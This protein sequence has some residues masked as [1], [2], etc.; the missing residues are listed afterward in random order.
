MSD[1]NP[2]IQPH[3]T[4]M[5]ELARRGSE[6]YHYPKLPVLN[7]D[8]HR[9]IGQM[10]LTDGVPIIRENVITSEETSGVGWPE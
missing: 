7:A 5:I 6:M 3:A 8:Q 9:K 2:R 4:T 10:S 1:K